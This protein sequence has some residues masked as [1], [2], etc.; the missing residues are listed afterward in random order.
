MSNAPARPKPGQ[1]LGLLLWLIQPLY[2]LAEL[3][4]VSQIR[5][6][7]NLFDNTISDAGA[8]T[9]TSVLYPWGPVPVCSP[10]SWLINSVTA[11]LGV[12]LA[13]GTVLVRDLLPAGPRRVLI[14][15]LAA[16]TGLS[17]VGT[18]LVPLD[19][20]LEL[21]V[22]VALPQFA[23]MPIFLL[24]LAGAVRH[25]SRPAA[26][27]AAVAGIGSLIGTLGFVLRIE[28]SEGSGLLERLALWPMY[29]AVAPVAAV[30]LRLPRA[31]T[32]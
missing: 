7:Y 31:R 18:G 17:L 32:R 11:L 23:T 12:A 10:L 3:I 28:Q 27:M 24:A 25:L 4:T 2:L 26:A 16:L 20:Q 5:T 9:C 15:G 13:V 19:R 21:H 6:P 14:V 30:M 8:E 29:L 22:I 1:R